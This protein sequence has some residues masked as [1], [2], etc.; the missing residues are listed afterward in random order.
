M[1]DTHKNGSFD[2]YKNINIE[3]VSDLQFF[4]TILQKINPLPGEAV[5]I[6]TKTLSDHQC[7]LISHWI[8]RIRTHYP[9]V[10]FIVMPG[11]D[12]IEDL[13]VYSIR[14]L[15]EQINRLKDKLES[16]FLLKS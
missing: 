9:H 1:N 7:E 2:V 11:D 10:I 6:R 5:V 3:S 12:T 4:L 13:E 16:S 15:L 14:Q 8:E